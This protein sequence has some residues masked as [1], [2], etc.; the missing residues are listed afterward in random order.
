M[1]LE[2]VAR[3]GVLEK[4]RLPVAVIAPE[5]AIYL[6]VRFDLEGREGFPDE[7][8]VLSYLLD[9]A[10]CAVVPF[11]AFGDHAN[12]GW[13]R[14]SVGAVSVDEIKACMVRLRRALEQAMA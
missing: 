14:F 8:S 7:A 5:G 2:W 9:E 12:R 3:L 1:T 4:K 13:A 6:S 10:G 11:S